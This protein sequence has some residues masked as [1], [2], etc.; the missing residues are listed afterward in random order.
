ML[1]L[2]AEG[3]AAVP[4]DLLQLQAAEFDVEVVDLSRP[5]LSYEALID[6]IFASDRVV[7]W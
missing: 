2:L 7:C 3:R 4:G 5:G 1:H 6:R